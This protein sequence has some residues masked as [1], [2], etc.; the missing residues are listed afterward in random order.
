MTSQGP[1]GLCPPGR[2]LPSCLAGQPASP[3]TALTSCGP[4]KRLQPT[5]GDGHSL[6]DLLAASAAGCALGHLSGQCFWEWAFERP[7]WHQAPGAPQ[8]PARLSGGKPSGH[9]SGARTPSCLARG[10][11]DSRPEQV[12]RQG[13][14]WVLCVKAAAY[15]Q[16]ASSLWLERPV[17]P[18]GLSRRLVEPEWGRAC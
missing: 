10:P 5:S 1:T 6:L 13:A 7:G 16:P 9:R 17:G 2:F 12:R 15:V 4:G 14:R 3:H 18:D 11:G 8:R